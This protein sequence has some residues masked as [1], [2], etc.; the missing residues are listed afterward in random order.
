MWQLVRCFFLTLEPTLNRVQSKLLLFFMYLF[1][2][3]GASYAGCGELQHLEFEFKKCFLFHRL[4]SRI[5]SD[6]PSGDALMTVQTP[7]YRNCN[8][9]AFYIVKA[10]R[11]LPST[12]IMSS[13]GWDSTSIVPSIQ[14]IVADQKGSVKDGCF[15]GVG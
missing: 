14:A 2:V 9:D 15:C 6:P 8:S 1:V 13:S 12:V 5:V 11:S 3:L 7:Y 4:M 10:L